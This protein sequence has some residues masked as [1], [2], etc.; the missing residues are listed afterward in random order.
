MAEEQ[1]ERVENSEAQVIEGYGCSCGFRTE[2][3]KEFRTYVVLVSL[4][5]GK[6]TH[7]SIGRVNMQ[8]GEVV[9]PVWDKRTKEQKQRST[10]GKNKQKVVTGRTGLVAALIKRTE[11][12]ADAQE[13]R[14]VPRVYTTDYSPIMR[15]VQELWQEGIDGIV[16]SCFQSTYGKRVREKSTT[17]TGG[18][19]VVHRERC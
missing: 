16:L 15:A 17:G 5:D 12:L 3:M 7:R 10:Y 4:H 11:I 19:M 2:D 13:V 6:G 18:S 9:M 14:F 8:T 1:E